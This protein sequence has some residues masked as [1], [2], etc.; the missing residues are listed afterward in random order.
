MIYHWFKKSR[1]ILVTP[2]LLALL[3]AVACGAT[4]E[5]TSPPPTQA[6]AA[7]ASPTSAPPQAAAATPGPR[8]IGAAPVATPTRAPVPVV[9][10]GDIEGTVF[11][12]IGSLGNEKMHPRYAAGETHHYGRLLHGKLVE[13]LGSGGV[14]PGTAASW[15]VNEDGTEWTFKLR[16]G[17]LFHNGEEATIDDFIFS[18]NRAVD[19][20]K[21]PDP[22]GS[23]MLAEWFFRGEREAEITGPM[24]SAYPT[25]S[26]IPAPCHGSPP[27]TPEISGQLLSPR[28]CWENPTTSTSRNTKRTR[29][30]PGLCGWW[31]VHLPS[32]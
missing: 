17:V 13:G 7:Q 3:F 14:T 29:S 28:A 11:L 25:Y 27:G 19:P 20:S 30:G 31:I 8:L 23:T 26:P 16:K 32:L 1:A 6:P 15:R 2:L 4:A 18:I 12:M 5:P 21:F 24:K 22:P 9:E 10:S